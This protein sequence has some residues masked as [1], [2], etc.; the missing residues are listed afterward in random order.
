MKHIPILEWPFLKLPLQ[1][2]QNSVL[3]IFKHTFLDKSNKMYAKSSIITEVRGDILV[4]IIIV[5]RVYRHFHINTYKRV[6][7]TEILLCHTYNRMQRKKE[8]TFYHN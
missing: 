5:L 2:K 4:K 8:E 7:T 6:F 3:P 1:I